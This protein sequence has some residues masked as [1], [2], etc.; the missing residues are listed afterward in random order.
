MPVNLEKYYNYLKDNGANIAPDLQSFKNTLSDENKAKQYYDYLKSNK[1]NVP[2]SYNTF[3]E[4]LG[5]KKKD[6]TK[7][8]SFSSVPS[9][10]T[11][12]QLV[13]TENPAD[14]ARQSEILKQKAPEPTD[15]SR[16]PSGMPVINKD[17]NAKKANEIDKHL[18]DLGYDKDF[19]DYIKRIPENY[20][21][22]QVI[23]ETGKL[24]PSDYSD[25]VLSDLYKKDKNQ[26]NKRVSEVL[27]R[28]SLNS[29]FNKLANE[30][31]KNPNLSQDEKDN[32]IGKIQDIANLQNQ[33]AAASG[34]NLKN[35]QFFVGNAAK[36]IR[37]FITD[38]EKQ[39][40]ALQDLSTYAADNFGDIEDLNDKNQNPINPNL[41]DY[42]SVAL[43]YLSQIDPEKAN[44]YNKY[45][46]TNPENLKEFEYKGYEQLQKELDQIGL[47]LVINNAKNK[48]KL[49]N[50]VAQQQG[51][52]LDD[53]DFNEYNKLK[54]TSDLAS[55]RLSKLKQ[56]YPDLNDLDSES[57]AQDLVGPR[58]SEL[59]VAGR[60]LMYG[61]AKTGKGIYDIAA[62]PFRSQQETDNAALEALGIE[63]YI[64]PK[65][66]PGRE[67]RLMV[68]EQA[69]LSPELEK[70][71]Q[72]IINDESL[73]QDQ[74]VDKM[75]DLLNRNPDKWVYPSKE[76]KWNIGI[77]SIASSLLNFS[78]DIAP[79]MATEIATEG[80]APSA[81]GSF[82]KMFGNVAMT[83]YADE[84]A[85]QM[86]KKSP[87]PELDAY[88]N[89][90]VNTLAYK[91]AGVEDLVGAIR[92]ASKEIGG[93]TEKVISR[94]DDNA[95][96]DA[97]KNP[98][99]KLEGFLNSA[100]NK[101]NGVLERGI[102]GLK[103]GAKFE[104]VMAGKELMQNEKLDNDF[105]KTHLVNLLNFSLFQT[106]LKTG[107]EFKK[108]GNETKE[109]LFL[110]ASN[111]NEA[112]AS[113]DRAL[114]NKEIT[115]SSANQIKENIEAASKVLEKVPMVNGKG[116]ELSRKEASELMFLKIKEQYIEDQ[117]KK[118]LPEEVK[119]KIT[120][121][122]SDVQDQIDKV[123]NGTFIEDIGKPFAKL[124]TKEEKPIEETENGTEEDITQFP[125]TLK[126]KPKEKQEEEEKKTV[127][128]ETG[129]KPLELALEPIIETKTEEKPVITT[130]EKEPVIEKTEETPQET[131]AKVEENPEQIKEGIRI[132][133]Q[134][135]KDQY[136]FSAEFDKRGGE[137]VAVDALSELKRKAEENGISV[138]QQRSNEVAEMDENTQPTEY[139]IIT[140]GNHLLHIDNLLKKAIANNEIEQIESLKKQRDDISLILRQ[141]GNKAGRNLGLFN[142]VFHDVTNG[143]INVTK[144][145][146]QRILNVSDVPESVNELNKSNLTADEKNKIK[147]Y[148]VEIEKLKNENEKTE[149]EI[150]K[151][152]QKIGDQEVEDAI[153]KAYEEGYKKGKEENKD[154]NKKSKQLKDLASKLRASDEMDK[155]LKGAGPL[156]GAEKASFIDLGSYKEII[157]NILEGA[158][159]I[160][161]KG[162]N[163]EEYLKNAIDKL[164]NI[165]KKKVLDDI[166]V[167]MSKA[168]LP[169]KVELDK[170]ISEIAKNEGAH[171]ITKSMVDEGLIDKYVKLSIT[172][173]LP[174]DK[175]I[176]DAT[177]KLKEILPGVTKNDVADAFVKRNQFKIEKKSELENIIK[178][179]TEDVKRLSIKESRLAALESAD[180]Y[181]FADTKE[182]K[183]KIKSDYEK[184]LDKKINDAKDKLNT[185]D[186][187]DKEFAKEYKKLETERN[188]QLKIVSELNK[189]LSD[190]QKGIREVKEKKEKFVDVPEIEELKTKVAE[191]DK[192]LRII[193]N[194][195]KK[196]EREQKRIKDK[197]DEINK[198]I[199]Y[200]KNTKSVFNQAIKNP[201]EASDALIK[202]RKERDEAYAKAGIKLEKNAKSPILIEREYQNEVEK[203]NKSNLT[204]S[205]KQEALSELKQQRD[206]D[207]KGSKQAVIS[208]LSDD[209]NNLKNENIKNANESSLNN[210]TE[211][212]DY[213]NN[214]NKELDNILNKLKPTGEKLEDQINRAYQNINDLLKNDT[215]SKDEKEKLEN[216]KK[217]LEKNNQLASDE[218]S[219]NRLKKQWENE[220]R[221]AK[222]SI[223]SGIYTKIPQNVYDYRRSI[224][225][226]KLKKQRDNTT[227]RLNRLQ[228]KAK[229]ESRD[230]VEKA[231]DASTK[232]LVSGV[233]TAE[234][235]GMAAILKPFVDAAV[236]LTAG[237]LT[238]KI[239]GVPHTTFKSVIESFKTFG[240]YKNKEQ[241][242]KA[243]LN[244]QKQKENAIVKLENAHK[245]GNEKDIKNAEKE[246]AKVDL[247][248][249][250]STLYQSIEANSMKSFLEYLKHGATDYDVE[251][252]KGYKKNISDYRTKLGKLGYIADGWIRSH[253]AMKSSIS[254]RPE[255][256]RSF[257]STLQDFQRKGMPLNEENIATAQLIAANAYEEGRLTNKTALSKFLSRIKGSER[258]PTT[259]KL[260]K[261]I[262]PVS[263]I[264][265]N[266][267]KRGVDYSS[268]GTEGFYRLASETKKGMNLNEA[269]G[270][271]YDTF[272]KSIQEGIKKIPLQ[273]RV[274]INGVLS[275][276][277]F[278]VGLG[279]IT[280]YGLANGQIK[281]GGTY[282]DSKKRKIMGSDGEQLKPG[283]WEFFGERSPKFANLF[284]NHLPEFLILA[285]ASNAY[286]INKLG[287]GSADQFEAVIQ[288]VEA[289]LPFQ[290]LAGLFQRGKAA[291]TFVDRFT[292]IPLAA[293]AAGVLDE[294]AEQRDKTD[295]FN[296]ARAN[297]GLGI[298][299]PTKDQ[300]K[301]INKINKTPDVSKEQ[302]Q[303]AIKQLLEQN[304]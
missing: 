18:Q 38:P 23:D 56:V 153:K 269:E 226:A 228:Q 136:N 183:N 150:N 278:G 285:L 13:S 128:I 41:N 236:E 44:F 297:V 137:T 303:E 240:K 109:A 49:Y 32:Q 71:R 138:E 290:T 158:A 239:T 108:I 37:Q 168:N 293:E 224:E 173:D 207:L 167:L 134:G 163:V 181:H 84:L 223:E 288:E 268:L 250:I 141:L 142:L 192:N 260:G 86:A 230:T 11:E 300:Q 24:I 222:T 133:K 186:K 131:A 151:N 243:I 294:K 52:K 195:I 216:I 152:I 88:G 145:N 123:Y 42:Q 212:A 73:S 61:L 72:D 127:E 275:R 10:P 130:E 198:E 214:I 264:A 304:Q 60:K 78:A 45:L 160:I 246:F 62:A 161:E 100:S 146:I 26:F 262:F 296:R 77:N 124:K 221:N 218:I 217:E 279:L 194:E 209:I 135:L 282:D 2:D 63:N 35:R 114:E 1:F 5:L 67:S 233:H 164:K 298:L 55:A 274:Y 271:T 169:S 292:R 299:N 9:F 34:E 46:N 234:K 3:S 254:A 31:D 69:K 112:I 22:P 244:L 191:A 94:L 213:Y 126:A 204:E 92:G 54:E 190:L 249:A 101:L 259:R 232:L 165:D 36:R 113:V 90:L 193:E 177:N 30:I 162:E 283:E 227:G 170:Q 119:K 97:L 219:A 103:S 148:V 157:A 132:S 140:A 220:I 87:N 188:R 82:A 129:E 179:K 17:E 301:I 65:T 253:T 267:T 201:K 205:E 172:E 99:S 166:R 85:N 291:Q 156:G 251:I 29:E 208:S 28:E 241:V 270:K 89:I 143:E 66:T 59:E 39:K 64:T 144:A 111:K 139:N 107:L 81:L 238:S 70:Q 265:F 276:G 273:E 211:K 154:K 4:V 115:L 284:L 252:G 185:Q 15:M 155:F 47:N 6:G 231:V 51:G 295:L 256:M 281:Y 14:L 215:I 245:S 302:K 118:D 287:G 235:V 197:I 117:M 242:E 248:Y 184:E 93:I 289:R 206:L 229:E 210:D 104:S 120:K 83:S 40:Q 27:W 178:N 16:Y 266:I 7:T 79:F 68:T 257:V 182:Q 277:L 96:K 199:E 237:R 196:A 98:N 95:I 53:K 76:T 189:K 25:E 8:F 102:E 105:I 91:A 200:V 43:N 225:L 20:R 261:I 280:L 122:L 263:T 187:K 75:M 176:E 121:D 57:V 258:Q 50:D 174:Y 116:E 80:M 159:L 33:E 171:N 255:M 110:A 286:Q 74:K 202:A 19:Q 12:S 203:I 147:P 175:V 125:Y 180:N 149:Q 272:I 58:S 21:Q 106:I 48:L 247:E